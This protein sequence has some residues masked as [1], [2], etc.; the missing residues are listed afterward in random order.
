MMKFRMKLLKNKVR[1]FYKIFIFYS[2]YFKN[3]TFTTNKNQKK[4]I[5]MIFD[6]KAKHGGLVDRLKGIISAYDI[7]TKLN[8]D[9]K[10][11]FISPFEL[12]IFLKPN[13]YNWIANVKDLYWN[14]FQTKIIEINNDFAINPM[15]LVKKT[16][17]KKIFIFANVDYLQTLNPSLN[18][19]AANQLWKKYFDELFVKSP[20]L[21]DAIDRLNIKA[22]SI[23][24]HTRFTNI[25]GDFKDSNTTEVSD[26]Q[27]TV[28]VSELKQ[29]I[30]TINIENKDKSIYVFSD[31]ITFLKEIETTTNYHILD[32]NPVHVDNSNN[33]LDNNDVHLKTFLDFFAISNCEKVYFLINSC[34]YNSVFSKYASIVGG[35]EYFYRYID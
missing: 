13:Q 9:F 33:Y 18:E 2:Y 4:Q 34:T 3:I 31:S 35:K 28:I 19:I 7:A 12:D 26:E 25:L 29:M 30:N 6:G 27:K 14:P 15:E 24:V 16:N 20:F 21:S 8:A 17:K 32:G 1:P 10:I 5:I 22:D 11:H 23:A